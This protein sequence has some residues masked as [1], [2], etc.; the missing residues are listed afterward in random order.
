MLIVLAL[1]TYIPALSLCLPNLWWKYPA[2]SREPRSARRRRLQRIAAVN[3]QRLRRD[4]AGVGA[5]KNDRGGDIAGGAG[6]LE[7]RALDGGLLAR[8][9]PR[10][11]PLGVDES[12]RHRIHPRLGRQ[13]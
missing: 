8:G 3:H 7:Q 13:R 12:R 5:Q 6:A 4:H 10:P 1:V 11:R 9:R 2:A